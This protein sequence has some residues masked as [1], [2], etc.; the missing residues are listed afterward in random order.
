MPRSEA[1][2]LFRE[3]L[4]IFKKEYIW[5]Y[6]ILSKILDMAGNIDSGK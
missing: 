6:A 3:N 2:L 5:F 1:K 4:I